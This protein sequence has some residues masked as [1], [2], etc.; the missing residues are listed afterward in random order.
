MRGEVVLAVELEPRDDAEAVAQRVGQHAGAGRR[1]DEREGRQIELDRARRRPLAD[2]DVDLEVLQRRVQDLLDHRREAV[3]LVDEEHVARLEVG[4]QRRE[5]ARALEHRPGSLAQVHAHLARDDVRERGLAEPRR[6]EQQHVVER[7]AARA[8]GLDEDL[9]LPADLFLAYVLREGRRAQRALDLALLRRG[10]RA[11]DQPVG[12]DS[13]ARILP[14]GAHAQ[15]EKA[16][17][18]RLFRRTG[19]ATGTGTG[20]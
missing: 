19:S 1:A 18:S 4:E 16:A 7:L 9:E 3:D 5:V 20:C 2:H 17:R 11:G 8:R 15:R 12:F 13:H 10:R 6:A 14:D